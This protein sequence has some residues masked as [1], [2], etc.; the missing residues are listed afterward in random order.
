L[1][2][3]KLSRSFVEDL[4]SK[5]DIVDVISH[6]VNLRQSGRNF[7]ALCP[8]HPEKTPSFVVS[9]E[10]QIFKCF[11]CGVGGNAITFV[12]KY[13]GVSFWE[14][15]KRV[16]EICGVELPRKDFG[17]EKKE[18]QIAQEAGYKAALYFNRNVDKVLDYLKERGITQESIER[19]LLGYA[20]KGYL[21]ELSDFPKEALKALGLI[22]Q[23]GREFFAERL[24]IPI[25]NHSGKVVAFAG[26]AVKEGSSP[27]YINSPESELFKK[28][29][30][31]Y[32]FYQ[33]RDEI[34]KEREAVIVEGYFDVIS[35][36]QIGVKRAVAP[37]GTSLTENHA[38]FI[39]RYSPSP[40]LLFDSDSAGRKAAVRSAAHFLKLGCEPRVA[41]LPDGEDPDSMARREP[42]LLKELI[43]SASPF[44]EWAVLA[45]KG[46][47]SAER[48]EFLKL[49]AQS[50]SSVERVN[51]LLFKEYAALLAAEFGI[52]EKWIKLHSPRAF[53]KEKESEEL[54]PPPYEKAFL[55]ALIEGSLRLPVEISPTVFVSSRVAK[56]YTYITKAG[57]AEPSLLQ[58]EL[59]EEAPFIAELLFME[60]SEEELLSAMCRILAKELER[61]LKQ[62]KALNE[63]MRLKRMIF[64]L[65][66]GDL[67]VVSNLT[68]N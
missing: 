43:S 47:E 7:V 34:I 6:Y 5:I 65:K 29:S 32:G 20:P 31:L 45:A 9:P 49:V 58:A 68:V 12:E 66:K 61:R 27:K 35:L 63:K 24:I 54:P 50:I 17:E 3:P 44:I 64:G 42:E 56:I 11:G 51:P 48:G 22:G 18:L 60:V 39:K 41:Q 15:V 10:K 26:R 52:D 16:A 55:K 14:A 8:F 40:V 36:H 13:E 2:S 28:G 67:T 33:S 25:F 37:M 46:M 38:R 53:L 4:L 62:T 23:S 30:L 1:G 57:V 19:F 59:P 21:R